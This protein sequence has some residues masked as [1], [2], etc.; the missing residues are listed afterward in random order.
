M[1]AG[2][3]QKSVEQLLGRLLTDPVL[4]RRFT[5]SPE[6][7]ITDLPNQNLELSQI[8]LEALTTVDPA[9]LRDLAERLDRRLRRIDPLDNDLAN[10]APLGRRHD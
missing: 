5:D 4:R 10:D 8:E 2:M 6:Q 3:T 7:L 1:T 9:S